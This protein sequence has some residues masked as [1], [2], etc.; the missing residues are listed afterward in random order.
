MKKNL[1][2]IVVVVVSFILLLPVIK[3]KPGTPLY[4]QSSD[5][6][7]TQVGSPFE[8]SNS[9]SRYVSTEAMVNHRSFFL[10]LSEAKMAAPDVVDYNGKFFSIFTPGVSFLGIPFYWAGKLVGLPQVFTYLSITLF[11]LIDVL[12]ISQISQKLGAGKYSAL[13]SGLVFLFATN[14]LPYSQTYTQHIVSVFLILSGLLLA[15]NTRTV[16]N[17]LLFGGI[18]SLAAL[19]DIPNL[20]LL[21][22]AGLY[23]LSKSFKFSGKDSIIKFQFYPS[24]ILVLVGM[25]PGIF[26]FSWYN[27]QTTGS[28]TRMAQ[29]IGRTHYFRDQLSVHNPADSAYPEITPPQEDTYGPLFYV[30]FETRL[31][32]HGL[33]VLLISNERAW[34]Y[35]SPVILLGFIGFYL[36]RKNPAGNTLM[37][38]L[39]ATALINIV[40]YSMFGDP[41]GGWAFGPR[42]LIPAA[43]IIC[44]GLG[45]FIRKYGRKVIPALG[46]FILLAYSIYISSLGAMTSEAI[47]PKVEALNLSVKTPYT[48]AL[49][50]NRV[51]NNQASSLLYNLFFT[52]KISLQIYLSVYTVATL[53]LIFSLY[54]IYLRQENNHV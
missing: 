17:N 22:P 37:A 13:I 49:N 52:D 11:A 34:V 14:A 5:S 16:Q 24:V 30:P 6:R 28:Y 48:Y 9:S 26:L 46:F 2:S 10:D 15:I 41:W 33:Y 23:I 32:L 29:F 18:I 40:I 31:Q 54:V 19:V 27:Y 36:A 7:D 38:L 3:G 47:P 43:A 51:K 45:I 44:S 35:Y 8:L 50:I 39:L 53:L 25:I 20:V 1:L 12:L 21:I 4:Y 42:Y